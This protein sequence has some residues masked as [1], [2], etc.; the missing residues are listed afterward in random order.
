MMITDIKGLEDGGSHVSVTMVEA[1][2]FVACG[3]SG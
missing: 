3:L 2:E 1:I